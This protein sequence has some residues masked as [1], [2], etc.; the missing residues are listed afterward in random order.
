MWVMYAW[1]AIFPEGYVKKV[2]GLGG[3]MDWA[4]AAAGRR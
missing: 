3:D 1:Q 2:R 4:A